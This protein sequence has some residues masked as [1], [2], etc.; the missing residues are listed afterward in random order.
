MKGLMISG[1]SSGQGKTV[2]TMVLCRLI[3][4]LGMDVAPFKTG[5]DCID[6]K[7]HALAAS[8]PCGN[9]DYH[10]QGE[11]GLKVA[12]GLNAGELAIIEGAMGYFDGIG[13]TYIGSSYDISKRINTNTVLVVTPG[14]Q[15]FSLIPKLMGMVDFAEGRIVGIVLN[16]VSQSYYDKIEGQIEKYTGIKCLGYLPHDE[17]LNIPSRYQGLLKPEE[18]DGLSEHLDGAAAIMSEY[19]DIETLLS[20]ATKLE[21]K[22]PEL[23]NK[24]KKI[25]IAEDDAFCFSYN[26]NNKILSML[27]DVQY[28]SPMK[29]SELPPADLIV[30]GGGYPELYVKELSGNA[31]MQRAIYE[32]SKSGGK[33][34]GMGAGLMYL[35]E[36]I[37]G[38]KMVGA[39]SGKTEI[40]N[41]TQ[42]FGYNQ[43]ELLKDCLLGKSGDVYNAKEFHKSVFKTD[44][45]PIFSVSK[46]DGKSWECGYQVNNTL[47]MYQHLNFA[48]YYNVLKYMLSY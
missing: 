34:L 45:E 40:T 24:G 13:N 19:V 23:E 7:Y 4:N 42:K 11:E 9:L 8:H 36:S 3:R 44:L 33:I 2:F 35:S 15:M 32:Y 21:M 12:L 29:D 28:F 1:G 16:K 47:G 43:I 37:D 6:P 5:P 26:E 39:L 30:L 41:K 46:S 25:L 38:Y 22:T 48:G 27:G 10:M 31:K 20:F 17:R 14:A 18:V